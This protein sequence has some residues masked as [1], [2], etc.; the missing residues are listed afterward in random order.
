MRAWLFFMQGRPAHARCD[1][2]LIEFALNHV[3]RA[4]V[5][6]TEDLVVDVEPVHD[7]GQAV[8]HFDATLGIELKV[9]IE[10]VVAEGTGSAVPV[11]SDILSVIGK[12]HAQRDAAAIIGG[13]DVPGMGGVAHEPRMI[14][15]EEIGPKGSARSRV[16]VV[17]GDA[18]TS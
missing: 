11:A 10:V 16:A 9:G 13:T 17:G 4:A 3:L 18:K 1:G 15:T 14:R 12:P 7:E 2:G 5:V 8:T 6:K